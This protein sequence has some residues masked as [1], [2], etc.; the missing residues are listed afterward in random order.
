MSMPVDDIVYVSLLLL[1]IPFGH[2]VKVTKS[3]AGKQALTGVV[4][5]A[6]AVLICRLHILH[7][8]ITTAVNCLIVKLL[9]QK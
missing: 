6:M 5:A 7:S 1:S 2:V 4:G 3:A 9:P 8:L